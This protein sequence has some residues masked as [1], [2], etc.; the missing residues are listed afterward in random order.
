[1]RK[2]MRI[3]TIYLLFLSKCLLSYLIFG[4][5]LILSVDPRLHGSLHIATQSHSVDVYFILGRH[6]LC[7]SLSNTADLLLGLTLSI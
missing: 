4:A 1:M 5:Y 7:L 2:Q 3:V 6:V